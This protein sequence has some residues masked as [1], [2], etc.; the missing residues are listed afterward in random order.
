MNKLYVLIGT[1]EA[2]LRVKERTQTW[3]CAGTL[4]ETL[5]QG[6]NG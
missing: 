2:Q 6:T 5:L 1:D 4:T 3:C